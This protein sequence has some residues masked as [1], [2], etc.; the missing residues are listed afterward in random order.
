MTVSPFGK[1]FPRVP[2]DPYP[3]EARTPP[4]GVKVLLTI[5]ALVF[6]RQL[7][8]SAMKFSRSLP[9]TAVVLLFASVP[10]AGAAG[11]QPKEP[12]V[13][14][15]ASFPEELEAIEKMLL[16]ADALLSST[17]ING[18]SFK[19][20]DV[21]GKRCVFFLTGMSYVN[22][23]ASTQLALDHFNVQAV[24]FTGI[25]GGVNPAFQPGDVVIPAHWHHHGEM[26]YF[27]E[28]VPGSGK[29]NLPA[30]YTQKGPNYGMMFPEWVTVIRAGLP[31]FEQVASFP[32]DEK[33]LAVAAD[34]AA[35]LAPLKADGRVCKVSC[36]GEGAS[37][38][39]FCDNAA[40]RQWVFTTFKADCLDMESAPI[41]QVCWQNKT[42]C[43]IVR[44][45]SDL[46]G[47]QAGANEEEIY[48]Q[49]AADNSAK[50]LVAI[51]QQMAP[52]IA[53]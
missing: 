44:G 11:E 19:T 52:P 46:A 40:Y 10:R 21:A 16:P 5:M 9:W 31:K 27:H 28:D 23:A 33:L 26:G 39:V 41:A 13:A 37:A 15:M 1:P 12:C 43:L 2:A 8:S 18:I 30:W 42:P 7:L 14:V 6:A 20:A 49:A 35:K 3:Q 48:L 22:A 50:V 47:G 17:E 29:Y 38:T 32:A 51:I 24:L 4:G 45:L 34:A 53:R 25:A 36:G